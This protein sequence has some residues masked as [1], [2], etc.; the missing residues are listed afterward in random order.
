MAS[1]SEFQLNLDRDVTTFQTK[2][3]ADSIETRKIIA[4]VSKGN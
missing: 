1:M 4:E 3:E 2:I